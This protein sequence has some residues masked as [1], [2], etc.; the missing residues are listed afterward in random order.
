MATVCTTE[1][2][3]EEG[4]GAVLMAWWMTGRRDGEPPGELSGD[5]AGVTMGLPKRLAEASERNCEKGFSRS[6]SD[7]M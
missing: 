2:G 5:E 6:S 1:A 3:R 4:G 7:T